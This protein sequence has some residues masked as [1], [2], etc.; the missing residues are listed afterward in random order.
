MGPPAEDRFKA[1]PNEPAQAELPE[2]LS[3]P[4]TKLPATKIG[5]MLDHETAAAMKKG[6]KQQ[7]DLSQAVSVCNTPWMSESM[8]DDPIAPHEP[9]PHIPDAVDISLRQDGGLL[10]RIVKQGEHVDEDPSSPGAAKAT[11]YKGCVI[12]VHY[13]GT[14]IEGTRIDGTLIEGKEFDNSRSRPGNFTFTLGNRQVIKGWEEG[15]ATMRK[16]EVAELFCRSDYAYGAVGSDP[17]VPADTTLKFVVE[18]LSFRPPRKEKHGVPPHAKLVEGLRLKAKG[19]EYFKAGRL[20][21]ALGEYAEAAEWLTCDPLDLPQGDDFARTKEQRATCELNAATCALKL[22]EYQSVAVRCTG[23]IERDAAEPDAKAPSAGA[24]VCFNVATA[25]KAHFRR[26]TALLGLK[27]WDAAKDDLRKAIRLDPK[28]KDIRQAYES[29]KIMEAD[30]RKAEKER[31]AKMVQGAGG[32]EKAAPPKKEMTEE[33]AD[34]DMMSKIAAE[35]AFK[36]HA[37]KLGAAASAAGT[38][39]YG[40]AKPA[41][42]AP[43]KQQTEEEAHQAE[44]DMLRKMVQEQAKR[45]KPHV[46]EQKPHVKEQKPRDDRAGL[47]NA[48]SAAMAALAKMGASPE[49][50]NA[51]SEDEDEAAQADRRGAAQTKKG[52]AGGA[53]PAGAQAE[54]KAEKAV[55]QPVPTA[56]QRAAAEKAHDLLSANPG[57]EDEAAIE[58]EAAAHFGED[59]FNSFPQPSAGQQTKGGSAG[60]WAGVHPRGWDD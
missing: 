1:A 37:G 18:L 2:S 35:A 46:E 13:K 12:H 44:V 4:T 30:E 54:R 38:P 52:G 39:A 49:F 26:G 41:A 11:P 47:A 28:A 23:V 56:A 36:Q 59:G 16:G 27:E 5:K 24:P 10:K 9:M 29:A 42:A 15:V 6:D 14:I 17:G 19:T 45:E 50:Q 51:I 60:S 48:S 21:D 3:G 58:A 40:T 7:Y 20:G 25:T 31:F 22:G 53:K 57:A 43:K 8:Q 32:K 55:A 34:V 33:E